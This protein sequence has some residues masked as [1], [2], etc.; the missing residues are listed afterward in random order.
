MLQ[1]RNG[2]ESK[3][4]Q[5]YAKLAGKDVLEV[6]CGNGRVSVM[7]APFVKSL[8]AIDPDE[9]QLNIARSKIPH[10][11]FR[12]GSG[13][14]LEFPAESFDIVTFTFSLHHQDTARSVAEAHRVLRP[15]GL[16][17]AIEP[18]VEGEVHRFFRAFRNED[19]QIAA[20]I[21]ALKSSKFECCRSETF[22]VD[23]SFHDVAELH[24]YFFDH[25]KKGTDSELV[26]VLNGLLG[27]K[28]ENRPIELT[29]MVHI[30]SLVKI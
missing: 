24:S 30:T 4:I 9:E 26:T 5:E 22:G 18:S 23:W 11:D 6:G 25:F 8:I 1:D 20:V 7:I 28:V 12:H 27:D 15:F 29:E 10:V 16:L 13:E 2:V 17:L 21:E 14:A 3:K 19:R